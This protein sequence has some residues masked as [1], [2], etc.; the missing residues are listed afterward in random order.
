[1]K[2]L[3]ISMF[4][5]IGLFISCNGQNVPTSVATTQRA[6]SFGQVVTK[7]D[8]K[9]AFVY[10]DKQ[11][12]YWFGSKNIG[13]YKYDGKEITLFTKADGLVDDLIIKVQEDQEGK[14]YFDTPSGIAQ[15]DGKSFK[16]LDVIQTDS[17]K[18]E[19]KSQPNDLWFSMGWESKGAYR[20]DGENLYYLEFPKSPLEDD[21]YARHP[22]ASFS[23]YGV[24]EIYKNSKGQLW[25]GTSNMGI[26]RYDGKEIDWMH[27]EHLTYT[28]QGGNFGIRS[29]IEDK[30][31]NF[32]ICNNK[33]RYQIISREF[34]NTALAQINYKRIEGIPLE[35][36]QYFLAIIADQNNDLWMVSMEGVWR[37]DGTKLIPYSIEGNNVQPQSIAMDNKDGIWIS[38][39]NHGGYKLDENI[40]KK[41]KL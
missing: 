37:Y 17:N 41:I 39:Q 40:F 22:N 33:Y 5:L 3:Y 18:N 19:W 4:T 25:F 13:I 6:K 27:E 9:A 28:P 12:N 26:Y 11:G 32:W 35:E 34:N 36:T 24:Y 10:Q 38:T 15:F 16:T 2:F 29:I 31:G 7:L 14:L 20:F 1:M 21:F 30:K 8:D 23:P